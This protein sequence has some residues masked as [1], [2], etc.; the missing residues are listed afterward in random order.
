MILY[1]VASSILEAS[2]FRFSSGKPALRRK[3][4]RDQ[5]IRAHLV[6]WRANVRLSRV[7]GRSRLLGLKEAVVIAT[8]YVK[9]QSDATGIELALIAKPIF[10]SEVCWVFAYNSVEHI[11]TNSIS[12]ALAG[13]APILIDK[14]TGAQFVTGTA[15]PTE[16]YVAEYISKN[17]SG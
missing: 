15:Y 8:K 11:R 6:S 2:H 17:S 1:F 14:H 12:S 16:H 13:N 3:R 4:T 7:L 10:E 9:D 5:V